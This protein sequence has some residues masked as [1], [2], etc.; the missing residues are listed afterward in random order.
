MLNSPQC[1]EF[2]V[3]IATLTVYFIFV[4]YTKEHS[5]EVS[6]AQKISGARHSDPQ[7]EGQ[8]GLQADD[9]K[10]VSREA[11]EQWLIDYGAII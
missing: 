5:C 11:E 3:L 10:S 1:S 7:R 4:M 9:I 2:R 8:S 6:G